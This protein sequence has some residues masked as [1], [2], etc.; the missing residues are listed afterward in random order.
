MNKQK[1]LYKHPSTL[2]MQTLILYTAFVEKPKV[3]VTLSFPHCH[4]LGDSRRYPQQHT[5]V[6]NP[7]R[8]PRLNTI[9]IPWGYTYTFSTRSIL[10]QKVHSQRPFLTCFCHVDC[11]TKAHNLGAWRWSPI[12]L[13]KCYSYDLYVYLTY[14]DITNI[15][16]IYVV[17]MLSIYAI[18]YTLSLPLHGGSSQIRNLQ[19][20]M[21]DVDNY[22]FDV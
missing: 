16:N 20:P 1:S 5:P 2:I 3:F 15:Y 13:K 12:T 9:F 4:I 14:I 10:G 11:S 17:D 7:Y 21:S 8:S 6:E 19:F 18:Y 22:I